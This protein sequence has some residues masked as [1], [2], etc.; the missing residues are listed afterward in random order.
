MT[1]EK[2]HSLVYTMT[3]MKDKIYTKA[4][5][6]GNYSNCGPRS[7]QKCL[8]IVDDSWNVSY[9]TPFSPIQKSIM[10]TRQHKKVSMKLLQV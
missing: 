3:H 10:N 8:H 5:H 6:L 7:V 2:V 9:S 4:K 1:T